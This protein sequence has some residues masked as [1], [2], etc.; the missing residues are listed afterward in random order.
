MGEVTQ[1]NLHL[2]LPWKISGISELWARDLGV[3]PLEAMQR[4]YATPFYNQLADEA[5]KYWHYSPEQLY[6]LMQI[7]RLH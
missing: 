5:T 3:S 2:L 7:T 6:Q 1:A 4:F